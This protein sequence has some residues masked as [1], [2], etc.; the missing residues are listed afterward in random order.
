MILIAGATG[1]LGGLIAFELKQ[2]GKAVRALT[3]T[4][5][6]RARVGA[7]EKAGIEV[8]VGDLRDRASLESACRGAETVVST[9][10][11]VLSRQPG[12]SFET[13]DRE[14]QRSLVDAAAHAGARQFV[15]VSFPEQPEEHPLQSAKRAVEKHLVEG[16]IGYTILQPTYFSESWLS[17]LLGFD[18]ASGRVRVFGSLDLRRN[19]I[20]VQDVA[21][22]AV[23]AV[24]NPKAMRRTFAFGGPDPMTMREVIAIFEEA[25]GR[26]LELEIVPV[27]ALEAQLSAAPDPV[28][29]TFAALTLNYARSQVL[30]NSPLLGAIPLT[31]TTVRDYAKRMVG[32]RL[33]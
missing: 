30:D 2:R 1:T 6:D 32:P 12:D 7:L 26:K 29:K 23:G 18:Y 11:S 33:M 20:S 25:T 16:R 24:G 21:H 17:P 8:V 13:V 15:F 3:R 28:S 14:G 5:S 22:A 31:M 27:E 19:W 10:T 4:T 9:I